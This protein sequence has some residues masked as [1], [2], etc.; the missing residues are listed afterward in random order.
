[1]TR[2]PRLLQ[3]AMNIK[4]QRHMRNTLTAR[5]YFHYWQSK[6][7]HVVPNHFYYPI[8]DTRQLSK[9]T[10]AIPSEMPGIDMNLSHQHEVLRDVIGKY[11]PEFEEIAGNHSLGVP[12]FTFDND[13]FVGID[14]FVL[15][16]F[17]REYKPRTVLEVGSGFST[18]ISS[19]ALEKNGS[20][21]LICVEPYPR[22]FIENGLPRVKRLIEA[23]VQEVSPEVFECLR[24]GDILFIDSS[25]VLKI[26]SDV[27]FL[28]LKILPVLKKGVL[29]HIHDIFFPF[30]YPETWIK[31]KN[32]FWTEQYLLQ[33][34]L[35]G[36]T[37]YRVKFSVGYMGWKNL[38]SVRKVF[39]DYDYGKGGGSFWMEKTEQTASR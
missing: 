34:F 20:G 22:D 6:G 19:A 38:S 14:P 21:E 10:W 36:N 15:H 24:E 7:Y 16:A 18:L 2:V 25:H 35:I 11:G 27:Q 39:P 37:M 23:P 29:V 9:E 31:E 26:G 30:E 1:M 3:W 5:K 13:Q 12:R 28:F 32:F 8:P 33:A 4:L 17:I